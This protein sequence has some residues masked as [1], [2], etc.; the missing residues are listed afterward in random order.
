MFSS[1]GFAGRSCEI[2]QKCDTF[3]PCKN[4][5]V[6][7][8]LSNGQVFCECLFGT[9]GTYCEKYINICNPNPCNDGICYRFVCFIFTQLVIFYFLSIYFKNATSFYCHCKSGITGETCTVDVD[10]VFFCLKKKIKN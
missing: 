5:A 7:N 1:P 4:N 9:T 10:E 3:N 8:E 6:C 2:Q